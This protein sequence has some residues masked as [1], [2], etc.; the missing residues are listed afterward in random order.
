MRG[1]RAGS[2]ALASRAAVRPWGS[3][4]HRVA[5]DLHVVGLLRS[6]RAAAFAH[7]LVEQRVHVRDAPWQFCRAISGLAEI[8][9]KMVELN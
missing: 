2:G 8:L 9:I 7:E 3:G 4:K 6:G 1:L 5:Q